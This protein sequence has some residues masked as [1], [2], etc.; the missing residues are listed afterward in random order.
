[1]NKRISSSLTFFYK[2]LF[3]SIWF[4]GLFIW[5]FVLV[6]N[7]GFSTEALTSIFT[8][9]FSAPFIY[10]GFTKFKS[11][12]V[13]KDKFIISNFLKSIEVEKADIT[14]VTEN[15]GYKFY[16][17]TICLHFKRPTDFGL[18]I[19]FVA[20]YKRFCFFHHPVVKQ[21]KKFCNLP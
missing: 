11:V 4:S 16:P 21:I 12:V 9:F 13:S 7:H 19:I 17:H 2:I 8:L 18:K 15:W 10:L 20:Q 1:M 14:R 6:Y 5:I 3:P